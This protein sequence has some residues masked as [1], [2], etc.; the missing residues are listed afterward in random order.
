MIPETKPA[1]PEEVLEHFGTKGMHWGIRK[2]QGSGGGGGGGAKPAGRAKRAARATGRG[3]DNTLFEFGAH[4]NATTQRIA[5]GASVKL[6]KDLPD[7]KA[8][9][10]DYGKLRNRVRHPLAP[11]AKAYRADVKKVYL[12]HL[13]STA[14]EMTNIRGTRRYTLKEN[15]N[16]TTSQ[17]NWTIS[18]EAVK[19]ASD[20]TFKVRP[21]F[22]SEGWIVDVQIIKDDDMAQSSDFLNL[23]VQ[24]PGSP[25]ELLHFGKKGMK[26]GVTNPSS[27]GRS[28]EFGA[29]FPTGR[30][31]SDEIKRARTSTEAS[32]L[33]FRREKDPAKKI[34]LKKAYLNNPDRATALRM[35]RG[36]KVVAGIVVG[37]LGVTGVGVATGAALGARVKERHIIEKRQATGAY[38]K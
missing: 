2:D 31:R 30:S 12:K 26:W 3:V 36:E 23:L 17:Y 38:N 22:D 35:T 4:S 27:R 11:E 19:H 25:D 10:G 13:E 20:G 37:A 6:K 14:N 34:D 21:I 24:K 29:K 9:H 33:A 7:I 28:Q 32:R 15:G 18:T 5:T 1:S 16:P 8:R